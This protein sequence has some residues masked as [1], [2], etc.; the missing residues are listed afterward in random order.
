MNQTASLKI[1]DKGK[2]IVLSSQ[3]GEIKRVEKFVSQIANE[4][5]VN[6]DV[7]ADMLVSLTEAVNNAIIHGNRR[8]RSKKVEVYVEKSI[9]DI[10]FRVCDQG[11]GF[12]YKSLPDPTAP[13]NIC[14]C[15]GRGVFLMQ[16]LCDK[17][18]Y[19]DNG[20]T[21]EMRFRIK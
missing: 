11:K 2:H 9:K 15:G 20:R 4:L 14:T 16:Q 3:Q 8:D 1:S 7:Y 18:K 10:I 6:A 13:E 5:K 17:I 12:D 19:L 21:V